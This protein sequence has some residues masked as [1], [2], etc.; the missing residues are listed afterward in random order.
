MGIIIAAVFTAW[1]L[2]TRHHFG[3]VLVPAFAPSLIAL[4]A[5]GIWQ[6]GF[7]QFTDLGWI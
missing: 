4:T 5:F 1:G 7:P 2:R 6:R 3:R